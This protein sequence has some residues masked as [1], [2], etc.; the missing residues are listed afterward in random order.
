MVCPSPTIDVA[1]AYGGRV[2]GDGTAG[3]ELRKAIE[4]RVPR[5]LAA[6]SPI[7]GPTLVKPL[8]FDSVWADIYTPP[9]VQVHIELTEDGQRHVQ[10]VAEV[11]FRWVRRVGGHVGG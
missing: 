6:R 8:V 5:S 10:Q 9:L 7:A 2:P 11:V 1:A 3:L 4:H